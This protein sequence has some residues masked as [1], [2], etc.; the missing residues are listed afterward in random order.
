MKCRHN[1]ACL[2]LRALTLA[3]FCV[4][5]APPST[6]AAQ[7]PM[8]QIPA[9]ISVTSEEHYFPLPELVRIMVTVETSGATATETAQA[10]EAATE[11]VKQAAKGTAG[12]AA[13]T[14]RRETFH[15]A[16]QQGGA[17]TVNTAVRAQ[18]HIS[19]ETQE[20]QKCGNIIDQT[21]RA[22]AVAVTEVEYLADSE[23]KAHLEALRQA[24]EKA[25]AKAALA[26][27]SSGVKLGA[28]LSI[29]VTEEP[30]GAGLRDNLERGFD[31]LRAAEKDSSVSVTVRYEV[32]KQ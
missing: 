24:T 2:F 23:G 30:P 13:F 31:L 27:A 12:I 28:V 25:K 16:A 7:A 3:G 14:I 18:R 22:G 8:E 11:K 19:I 26:A 1:I 21:L 32:L 4:L 5:F 9:E 15:S 20:L 6:A 17:I 10:L 29:A